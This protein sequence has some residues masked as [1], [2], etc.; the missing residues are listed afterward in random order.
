LSNLALSLNIE[1]G[2]Y[3][4]HMHIKLDAIFFLKV[5]TP[6]PYV[7]IAIYF[8]QLDPIC[9]YLDKLFFEKQLS[10]TAKTT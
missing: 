3:G 7:G 4:H 8:H 10:V 2:A 1:S 6:K 9:I 5:I